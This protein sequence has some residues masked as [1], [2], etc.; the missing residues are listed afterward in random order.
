MIK[1]FIFITV[2]AGLLI[3]CS[4]NNE[5]NASQ[6]YGAW[7]KG[8][9]PGDTIVFMNDGGRHIVQFAASNVAGVPGYSRY[10]YRYRQKKLFISMSATEEYLCNSFSWV[11]EGKSF[12]LQGNDLYWYMSSIAPKYVYTKVN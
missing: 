3:A 6:L 12:Q 7:A 10:D 2:V 1:H 4:K 11:Q 9:Q 8:N 5:N